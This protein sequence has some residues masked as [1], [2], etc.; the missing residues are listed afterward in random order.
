MGFRVGGEV[1]SGAPYSAA[2][3]KRER[4]PFRTACVSSMYGCSASRSRAGFWVNIERGGISPLSSCTIA[5]A[6]L[7]VMR[8]PTTPV[9]G[10]L[11]K[12]SCR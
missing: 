7:T 8:K 1:R 5:I 10:A 6:L 12:A 4:S 2:A 9:C 3:L 11:R